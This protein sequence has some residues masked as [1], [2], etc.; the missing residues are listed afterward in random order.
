M[1]T[2]SIVTLSQRSMPNNSYTYVGLGAA[3]PDNPQKTSD[4]VLKTLNDAKAQQGVSLAD[5]FGFDKHDLKNGS[6]LAYDENKGAFVVADDPSA[7]GTTMPTI[8]VVDNLSSDSS[9]DALSALQGKV[10]HQ[11][12]LTNVEVQGN[13]I[14]F[15]FRDGS[16]KQVDSTTLSDSGLHLYQVYYEDNA[17]TLNLR[18]RNNSLVQTSLADLKVVES[19]ES[20]IGNG[21]KAEPLKINRSTG[22]LEDGSQNHF[23]THSQVK[24]EDDLTSNSASH[25]PTQKSVKAYVDASI[26]ASGGDAGTIIEWNGSDRINL[27]TVQ[28]PLYVNDNGHTNLLIFERDGIPPAGTRM[29]ISVQTNNYRSLYFPYDYVDSAGHNIHYRTTQRGVTTYQFVSNGTKAVLVDGSTATTLD[30]ML[31][32]S[33][34]STLLSSRTINLN[35]HDLSFNN[36]TVNCQAFLN[37]ANRQNLYASDT[38]VNLDYSKW[39]KHSLVISEGIGSLQI[40]VQSVAD[41][42]RVGDTL[43][44]AITDESDTDTSITLS[45]VRNTDWSKVDSFYL[46]P[47]SGCLVQMNVGALNYVFFDK[48]IPD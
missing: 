43:A 6:T 20:L 44:L 34:T 32:L 46:A 48:K 11:S 8:N 19:D 1:V 41:S 10:L 26:V 18:L 22:S 17:Q 14:V 36:G 23:L 15:T 45:G 27:S 33:E 3:Y 35:N 40:N 29:E 31:L 37:K 39:H 47:S 38:T 42:N 28:F 7:S 2:S 4:A 30:K 9:S 12:L 5:L 16:T 13:Q 25:V 24:N 21:T